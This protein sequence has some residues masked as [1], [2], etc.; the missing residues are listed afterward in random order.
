MKYK[1]L[2]IK[3][4][5]L[6]ISIVIY[7]YFYIF[8]NSLNLPK[9][10]FIVEDIVYQD[11]SK[12]TLEN[13]EYFEEE[14]FKLEDNINMSKDLFSTYLDIGMYRKAIGNLEGSLEAYQKASEYDSGSFVSWYNI[15][16]VYIQMKDYYKAEENFFIAISKEQDQ[17]TPYISLMDLYWSKSTLNHKQIKIIYNNFIK[18]NNNYNIWAKY[19]QYLEWEGH[20]GE[21]ILLWEKYLELYPDDINVLSVLDRLK[22]SIIN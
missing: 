22:K 21:A 18:L 12:I 9:N 20:L 19:G 2:G 8:N 5:I 1:Y 14:L 13:K 15:A 10:R 3:I 17:Y 4:I 6:I 16:N 11:D 7:S